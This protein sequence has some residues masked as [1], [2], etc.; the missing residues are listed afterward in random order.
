[1]SSFG[2]SPVAA[3]PAGGSKFGGLPVT[4]APTAGGSKFGGTPV[5][6]AAPT[7]PAD[8]LANWQPSYG[9]EM[10]NDFAS[11]PEGAWNQLKKDFVEGAGGTAEEKRA[12]AQA[13][14]WDQM[15]GQFKQTM[16]E[17][18]LPLDA[19]NLAISPV[20]GLIRAV[21]AKPVGYGMRKAVEYTGKALTPVLGKPQGKLP[22]QAEAEDAAM[23]AFSLASPAKG[24]GAGAH[25]PEVLSPKSPDSTFSHIMKRPFTDPQEFATGYIRR[26]LDREGVKKEQA[27]KTLS[28]PGSAMV[29][30]GS[31]GT[32]EAGEQAALSGEGRR[33]GNKLF[34]DERLKGREARVKQT[35]DALA[36]DKSYYD[37]LDQHLEARRNNADPLYEEA[38]SGGSHA[39]LKT[40]FENEFNEA[41]RAAQQA[42]QE[43]QDADTAITMAKSKNFGTDNV[44]AT[45][46]HNEAVRGAESAKAAA[47]EKLRTAEAKRDAAHDRLST[48]QEHEKNGVNGGIWSE[49]LQQFLNDSIVQRGI[50]TGM[51]T[52]QLR[53]LAKGKPHNPHEW[54][55]TGVDDQ[56]DPIV[57]KVPNL[58]AL[59]A[60]K[61]GLD[62][63]LEQDRDKTTGKLVLGPRGKAIDDVRRAYV[64]ELDRLTAESN[65]A[66]AK[67]RAAWSG[68]SKIIDAVH[69]G[70][71]IL[72]MDPEQI[73]KYVA[74]LSKE[75]HDGLKIGVVRNLTDLIHNSRSSTAGALSVAKMIA[76]N[77]FTQSKLRAALKDN[78]AVADLI[79][80]AEREMDYSRRGSQVLGGSQ[81][82]RR[83]ASAKEFEQVGNAM[84]DELRDTAETGL[85]GFA[86]TPHRI[87]MR[88]GGR[89]I[90]RIISGM[91]NDRREALAK[92]L[93]STNHDDNM[94]ALDMIY[95][96]GAVT[97]PTGY[98]SSTTPVSKTMD[99]LAAA[100][101][102][103]QQQ[104]QQ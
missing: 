86:T 67:A 18:K 53:A 91:S 94:R 77:T 85:M 28:K 3:A 78:K 57:S 73:E 26:A 88:L 97:T 9:A 35:V 14:F 95:E 44:Y 51:R 42:R 66:Y 63:M 93:F 37:T 58:R 75:E 21:A 27:A 80:M 16:A 101:N 60:G 64:A 71:E 29:D 13:P 10:L 41:S 52:E 23:E 83:N 50:K 17:G 55:Q 25:F 81:T 39:A 76:E 43:V 6:A 12:W 62:E 96:E 59:D 56:G 5:E 15:K 79:E 1:M 68:P 40:Q 49:R 38:F 99:R 2:G 100:A 36:S 34:Y 61:R 19:F 24:P 84:L 4:A 98:P 8:P 104:P 70:R 92:L 47:E 74:G 87:G 45:S 11:Q 72:D 103:P 30:V 48:A 54:G 65:P 90:D 102:Q 22:T 46:S 20:T 89:W 33:L 31:E 69:K 82:A 7:A 32:I